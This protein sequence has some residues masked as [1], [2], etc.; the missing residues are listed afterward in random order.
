MVVSGS[1]EKEHSIAAS[2]RRFKEKNPGQYNALLEEIRTKR[3]AREARLKTRGLTLERANVWF[4]QGKIS[5]K[6][7]DWLM[8]GK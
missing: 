3:L 2:F 4:L 8:D 5:S 7:F 6:D 1:V